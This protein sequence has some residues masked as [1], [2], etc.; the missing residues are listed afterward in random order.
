MVN[1]PDLV[2]VFGDI[3]GEI[4]RNV[5]VADPIEGY[6]LGK[7]VDFYVDRLKIKLIGKIEDVLYVPHNDVVP[8]EDDVT[9]DVDDNCE[10]FFY[11]KLTLDFSRFSDVLE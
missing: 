4:G 7:L 8:A 6:K 9:K 5:Y 3:A 2:S 11:I 1:V 10:L